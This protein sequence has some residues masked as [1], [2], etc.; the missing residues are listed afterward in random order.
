MKKEEEEESND[1]IENNEEVEGEGEEGGE[2]E[3]DFEEEGGRE[4]LIRRLEEGEEIEYEELIEEMQRS[5]EGYY[6]QVY[7]LFCSKSSCKA[8][9]LCNRGQSVS[10]ISD[11]KIKLFS[12][13]FVTRYL[14]E[15]S[16]PYK[17]DKCD[18][19]IQDTICKNC[20]S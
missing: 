13:D 11:V 18:C 20:G 5:R 19:L 14:D 12:T 2:E 6:E 1:S 17:F 4:E 8:F 16:N 9:P 10:L 15:K 7:F 3:E